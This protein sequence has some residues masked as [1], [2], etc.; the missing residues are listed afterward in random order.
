ACIVDRSGGAAEVGAPLI[1]LARIDVPA[2]PADAL[3]A[4]LA[5][6]PAQEPGSRGL[7]A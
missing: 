7:R 3:P 1:A 4:R 2:W 5:A 6:I